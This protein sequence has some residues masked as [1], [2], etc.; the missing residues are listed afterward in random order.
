MPMHAKSMIMCDFCKTSKHTTWSHTNF[1]FVS[2]FSS[3]ENTSSY[4]ELQ[5]PHVAP[6]RL[7]LRKSMWMVP[8]RRPSTYVNCR[9]EWMR[10][11][12][13]SF[14]QPDLLK[15][16]SNE[17]RGS[18][19]WLLHTLHLSTSTFLNFLLQERCCWPKSGS[20][21]EQTAGNKLCPPCLFHK[22]G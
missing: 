3:R 5:S 12:W 11:G 10:F 8:K 21:L 2:P 20:C 22:L 9:W 6:S 7:N 4:M 15:L 13:S 1:G 19:T 17:G 16:S 14:G 18:C